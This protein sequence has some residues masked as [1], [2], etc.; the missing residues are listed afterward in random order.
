MIFDCH[1]YDDLRF[2]FADL[3]PPELPRSIPCFLSQDPNRVAT[4]IFKCHLLEQ[5]IAKLG[6]PE[7]IFYDD[8]AEHLP[9]FAEW[10]KSQD[11]KSTI[12]DVVNK[13]A[14]TIQGS[15]I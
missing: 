9:K 8:R 12:V 2:E 11:I 4:F 5:T 7:L 3:F 1:I 13:T 10:A 6:V 14:T 15:S